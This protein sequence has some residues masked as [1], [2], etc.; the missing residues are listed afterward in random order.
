MRTTLEIDDEVLERIKRRAR[1]QHIPAGRL[2]SDLLRQQLDQPPNI[3]IT[4]GIPVLQGRKSGGVVSEKQAATM[5][6][7]LLRQESGL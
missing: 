3:V 6:E 4:N 1:H 2:I 7:E 5:I